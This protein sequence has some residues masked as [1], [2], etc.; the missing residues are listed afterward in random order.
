[1]PPFHNDRSQLIIEHFATSNYSIVGFQRVVNL[2]PI[3]NSEGA[4]TLPTSTLDVAL[5]VDGEKAPPQIATSE[6]IVEC[7]YS[8]IF[9]H[10][11]NNYNIF[12]EGVQGNGNGLVKEHPSGIVS[13]AFASLELAKLALALL[14]S[15]TFLASVLLAFASLALVH[16]GLVGRINPACL[17]GLSGLVG[18]IDLNSIGLGGLPCHVGL[19]L[20]GLIKLIG[21]IGHTGLIG[22]IILVCQISLIDFTS[23]SGIN[24]LVG[25]NNL[26][27]HIGL[28]G[29]IGLVGCIRHWRRAVLVIN[30]T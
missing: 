10:Y 28:F 20:F 29:H 4:N 16:I 7:T 27:N 17:S 2:I 3:L 14:A 15:S 8:I 18:L 1:M 21:L 26:V 11:C 6:L 23:L 25:R 19:C 12:C 9:L 24:G 13:L 30:N 5:F 22:L